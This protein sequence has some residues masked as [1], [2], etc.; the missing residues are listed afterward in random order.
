MSV[1]SRQENLR[2]V[3]KKVKNV[4]LFAILMPLK[5]YVKKRMMTLESLWCVNEGKNT[6]TQMRALN[7]INDKEYR[8]KQERSLSKERE[9]PREYSERERERKKERS[10]ISSRS[11]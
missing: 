11:T 5:T 2:E 4:R 8:A 10:K 1:V 7:R 9:R 3:K 6:H